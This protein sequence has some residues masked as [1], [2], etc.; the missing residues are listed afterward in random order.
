[1]ITT[2]KARDLADGLDKYDTVM[3]RD[4]AAEALREMAAKV[5]A[6]EAQLAAV[7][8]GG[9]QRL[10]TP[11][12]SHQ[13]HYFGDQKQR[14]CNWCNALEQSALPPGA[15]AG[16]MLDAATKDTK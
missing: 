13:Y 12:C 9:V 14:R 5:E 15:F 6:L 16:R 7:G 8:A 2:Q 11:A 1:M 3:D 4:E 10:V